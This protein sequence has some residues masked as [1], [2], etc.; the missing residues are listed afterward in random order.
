MKIRWSIVFLALFGVVAALAAAVLTASLSAQGIQAAIPEEEKEVSILVAARDLPSMQTVKQ[1]DV[2]TKVVKVS[3]T[4]SKYFS[5]PAQIVGKVLSLPVVEGQTFSSDNFPAEGSGLLLATHLPP[6]KRAIQLALEDYAGLEGLLYPGCIV[7]VVASFKVDSSA[8]IGRAVSTTLLQNIQVLG[9]EGNTV[10]HKSEEQPDRT[11]AT[12]A[13]LKPLLVTV[14]VDSRQAEALQLAM[15][16]GTV[17]L[18]LRNPGDEAISDSEATL[19][20]EGKLAQLAELLAPKVSGGER[21][22]QTSSEYEFLGSEIRLAATPESGS[23]ALQPLPGTTPAPTAATPG[24]PADAAH[25]QRYW[26]VEV[27]RGLNSTPKQFP[28]QN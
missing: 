1:E 6:G 20:A 24:A 13:A 21:N 27:I 25:S 9:V 26:E 8:K 15:E 14:M 5:E 2:V 11:R 10:V 12:R 28:V 17:S 23:S 4:P 16:H 3:A 22:G 18:A 7:D 19:L